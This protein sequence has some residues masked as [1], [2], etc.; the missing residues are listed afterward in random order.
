[1]KLAS[2]V[3]SLSSTPNLSTIIDFTFAATSDMIFKFLVG[4]NNL[5]LKTSPRAKEN[6]GLL[7]IVHKMM[8]SKNEL[9]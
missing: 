1:M 2:G 7:K 3:T 8:A 6:I 4:A 5:F 9:G